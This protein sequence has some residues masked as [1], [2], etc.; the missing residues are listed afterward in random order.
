MLTLV[1]VISALS[2]VAIILLPLVLVSNLIFGLSQKIFVSLI[3]SIHM[4][5]V[6]ELYARQDEWGY[7]G[8][9]AVKDFD[10][11][12]ASLASMYF[13]FF[14]FIIFF[15][16]STIFINFITGFFKSNNL[17]NANYRI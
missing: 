17:R 3:V 7:S 12:Y 14:I 11:T 5:S 2:V 4:I 8:W 16:L 6:S 9:M 1:S 15:L 13:P 10:F